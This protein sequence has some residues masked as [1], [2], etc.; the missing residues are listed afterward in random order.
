MEMFAEYGPETPKREYWFARKDGAPMWFAGIWRKW[1]GQRGTKANPVTGEHRLY[2]F[3]TCEPNAVVK[4]I[5]PKAM[6]V[7]LGPEDCDAWL[8]A[9]I[10]IALELQ[11]PA[12]DEVLEIVEG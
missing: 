2:S 11:R 12:G 6:P 10:E 5:H 8:N 3:L 9:S 1:E 4:P 7:V